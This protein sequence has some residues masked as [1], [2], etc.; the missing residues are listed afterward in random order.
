MDL[1]IYQSAHTMRFELSR[2]SQHAVHHG[3]QLKHAA[4]LLFLPPLHP[5]EISLPAG[6]LSEQDLYRD[7]Y[8]YY[9]NLF[10]T[11]GP[12]DALVNAALTAGLGGLILDCIA[13]NMDRTFLD[14]AATPG[15]EKYL[16]R[17]YAGA[18]FHVFVE[19]ARSGRQ[20]SCEQMARLCA[21]A[22]S[23]ELNFP[24]HQ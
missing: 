8:R 19:W 6:V 14:T 23:G 3:D 4:E 16:L 17:F 2:G 22:T 15:T 9:Y 11:L 13:R 12:Y 5:G 24:G 1:S 10:E 20:E 7:P 21:N 18:F